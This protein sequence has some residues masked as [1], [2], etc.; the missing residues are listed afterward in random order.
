M[1]ALHDQVSTLI[2]ILVAV[3]YLLYTAGKCKDVPDLDWTATPAVWAQVQ[4]HCKDMRIYHDVVCLPPGIR[5]VEFEKAFGYPG[6]FKTWEYLLMAGPYG[7]YLLEDCF[8]P[9]VQGVV[10]EYL[11]LIG[12]MWQKTSLLSSSAIWSTDCRLY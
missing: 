9:D 2:H 6:K 4:Q 7:K 12:L 10:F 11:D 5:S 8:H 1:E 3:S